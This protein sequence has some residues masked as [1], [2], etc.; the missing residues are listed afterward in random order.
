MVIIKKGEEEIK[1]SPPFA[2][3][4]DNFLNSAKA[5]N[6]FPKRYFFRSIRCNYIIKKQYQCQKGKEVKISDSLLI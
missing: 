4:P 2:F 3:S 6:L 1:T 5:N